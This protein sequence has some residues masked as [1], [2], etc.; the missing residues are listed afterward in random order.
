MT[1]GRIAGATA[2]AGII[3]ALLCAFGPKAQYTPDGYDYA[4]VMLMDRGVPYAQAQRQAAAFY[5]HQPD[6]KNP[7]IAPWFRGKPEYWEL[8]S[9]RRLDPWLASRLYPWRGFDALIAVSRLS[10][11]AVAMLIVLLAARFAPLPYG[12]VLAV[13]VSLFPPWRDLGRDALTDA[14]AVALVT[15]TLLAAAAF[16]AKRSWWTLLAFAVLCGAL[17]FTRPIPYIVLG[18]ALIACVIALRR[19]D[20]DRTIAAAWLSSIALFWTAVIAF[21]IQRAQPP[22]FAWFVADQ[23]RH[24]L[25]GGYAAPGQSLVHWYL[26]EEWTIAW[27]ALVKGIVSVLPLL[28][29]LGLARRRADPATPL[30][31]GACV[32][33]WLGAFLNPNRFDIVRCVVM[34][35]APVLAAFAA[36]AVAD[37]ASLPRALGPV[38]Q[39]VRHFFPR[40]FVPRKDT[41]KE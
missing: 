15:G 41:V 3:A 17:T 34:P 16:I 13:A 39:S 5:A 33:T 22:S 9:V 8:F 28:A 6:A 27:H 12:V 19:G 2:L 25:A 32:A 30:L 20:H 38:A 26:S 24:M 29:I 1:F 21:A 11:V 40:R 10:Y 18:A 37:G 14:L 31:A 23:Y 4:I 36:A 7:L 35:V